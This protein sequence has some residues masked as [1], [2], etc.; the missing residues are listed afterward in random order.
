MKRKGNK[1]FFQSG[2]MG[3]IFLSLVGLFVIILMSVPLAKK[4]S[5]Q[6]KI[7]KEIKDLKKEIEQIEKKNSSLKDLIS[8]LESDQFI[9]D[10]AREKLNYKKEGE[11]VVVL[12]NLPKK[13]QD[14]IKIYEG[15]KERKK[16]IKEKNYLKWIKY[17]FKN[18]K[19]D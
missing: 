19:Y 14:S 9:E 16:K 13:T 17:F 10:A 11:N 5:R 6:Y 18:T 7:N 1:K 4:V 3:Q 8:Y 15:N 12:E 2:V